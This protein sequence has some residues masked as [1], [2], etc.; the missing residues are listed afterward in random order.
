[1]REP[2]LARRAAAGAPHTRPGSGGRGA[3]WARRARAGA[4]PGPGPARASRAGARPRS[5]GRAGSRRRSSTPAASMAR[6]AAA[7]SSGLSKKRPGRVRVAAH[8]DQLLHAV[9]KSARHVL[10]YHRDLPRHLRARRARPRPRRRA[11]SAPDEG[12]STLRQQAHQRRLAR[13]VRAD[14]PEDLARLDARTTDRG[15]RRPPRPGRRPRDR[16]SPPP[17]R[18][19]RGAHRPDLGRARAEEID[20]ERRAAERGDD[21]HGEL[22][23]RDDVAG[24]RVGQR[25]GRAPPPRTAA[26]HQHAVV[27]A[28]AASG[29]TCGTIRPTKPMGPTKA[30]TAEVSRAAPTKTRR[31]SRSASTPSC[32]A[33][34]SPSAR[35]LSGRAWPRTS[36]K[37]ERGHEARRRRGPAGGDRAEVAEQPVHHAAQAVEV[38]DRDQHRDRRGEEDADDH[39]GQQQ[40][41]HRQAA[42]RWPR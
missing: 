31:L 39:P 42:A 23:R 25:A 14:D 12:V 35:R 3:R 8:E 16:R 38:Q 22:G 1:M 24:E 34:S 15:W 36:Q 33:L 20:E 18:D 21:A 19:E 11:G 5:A 40:R 13:G 37:P 28:A 9:R 41:V 29:A 7:R 26:G 27:R 30:T 32:C 10:G 6:R 2:G 4:A 17:A